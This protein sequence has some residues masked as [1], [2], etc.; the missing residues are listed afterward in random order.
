MSFIGPRPALLTQAALQ[1]RETGGVQQLL[2]GV[3]GSAQV[4]GR[5]S[6]SDQEKAALDTRYRHKMNFWFDCHIL[7]LT[8]RAVLTGRGAV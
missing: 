4:L 1:G 5:D 2:P 7:W 6:L 8:S 3:A